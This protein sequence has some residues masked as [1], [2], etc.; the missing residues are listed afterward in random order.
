LEVENALGYVEDKCISMWDRKK[1]PASK[2]TKDIVH[3]EAAL[4]AGSEIQYQTIDS[5]KNR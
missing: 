4:T 2:I 3:V 5:N 1:G